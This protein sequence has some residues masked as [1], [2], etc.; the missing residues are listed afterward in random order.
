MVSPKAKKG[1][2]GSTAK[3]NSLWLAPTPS[4]RWGELFFFYYSWTWITWALGIIVGLGLYKTF[5]KLGYLMIGVC[6]GL[7][8]F[9]LPLVIV[10]EADRST[11]I[12]QRWW[13]KANVWIAIYSFIGNYFWT[14]YFYQLLGA[15]YLFPSYLLNRVPI[16]LY[17]LTHAYFCFYHSISNMTLRRLDNTQW[18]AS[19]PRPAR[20]VVQAVAVVVLSYITAYM[21]TLTIAHFEY[22]TFTDKTAMYTVGSLFYAIYFFISF[23]MFRRMD[24]TA[25]DKWTWTRA[26]CDSLAAGMIVTILLDFWRLF[27]GPI[28]AYKPSYD[29]PASAGISFMS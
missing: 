17:L 20:L 14:H 19:L 1:S 4:K 22:Y 15:Q 10:G 2:R 13:F 25:T 8:C 9:L 29:G 21:E 26:A 6:G 11:P 24:E 12:T 27:V 16:P 28:A 7:P 23:P 5:D 18:V 3:D